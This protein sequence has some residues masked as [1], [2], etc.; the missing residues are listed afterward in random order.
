MA[1]FASAPAYIPSPPVSSETAGVESLALQACD[2]IDSLHELRHAYAGLEKLIAPQAVTDTEE[3]HP[4]RTE[5]SALVRVV[6]DE[7]R[8]RIETA[9]TTIQSLRSAVSE[10]G[11]Q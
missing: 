2:D 6:N 9:D 8:R 4:T 3:I 5:L 7:L 1:V 10:G 11:L